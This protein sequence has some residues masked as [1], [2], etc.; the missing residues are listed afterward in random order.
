VF[1]SYRRRARPCGPVRRAR[2]GAVTFLQRFGDALNLNVHFH[3]LVLDGVYEHYG[4]AGMRFRALPPPE[5]ADVARVVERV[6]RWIGRLLERRGLGAD[7][8]PMPIR[9]PPRSRLSPAL[10]RPR[11][12]A[13]SRVAGAPPG[14]ATALRSQL[15]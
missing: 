5:D 8:P 12:G 9:W 13:K 14:A 15:R 4:E 7:T 6:A 2:G 1:C 3:T 11:S 10:P